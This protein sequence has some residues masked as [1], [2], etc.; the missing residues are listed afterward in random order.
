[1]RNIKK[2][3][4]VWSAA[5]LFTVFITLVAYV[6]LRSASVVP[7]L[8]YH[9]FQAEEDKL[10]P[11]VSP[12]IFAVQMEFLAKNRY[13]VVGPEKIIAYMTGIEKM[14]AKTAAIT[15]DD[16]YYNF[17]KNAYPVLKKYNL[18]A[19]IFI[20]TDK[21]GASG[22]L[23]WKELGEMSD[24]GLITIGSHT[25]SH[26]WLPSVSVDEEKLWDELA[27]SKEILEKGLGRRVDFIC[28][29]S[30]AFNDLTKETA[31]K[32]GYK[33]AFTTNP[34]KKSGI[35]DIYAIR[36]IKMS[37][38]SVNPVILWGKISRYYAWF[39]ERR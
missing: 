39:K 26:P 10:V 20:A 5:A 27:H 13:N 3:L 38:A 34:A 17:Y 33:G 15:A 4:G 28:Y 12:E 25:R 7:V 16:G 6:A 30:G 9:S 18:P 19:T 29:P 8:M 37:S 36:R 32:A 35:D 1:M 24:S 31:K 11:C 21:I 23:G 14:P 2:R 22:Y